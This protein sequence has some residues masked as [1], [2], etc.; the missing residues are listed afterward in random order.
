MISNRQALLSDLFFR[1]YSNAE[2]KLVD[3]V[4]A[5]VIAFNLSIRVLRVYK[6]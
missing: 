5:M 6:K 1:H 4:K 2:F 3:D